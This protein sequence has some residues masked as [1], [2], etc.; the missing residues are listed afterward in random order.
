MDERRH[1]YVELTCQMMAHEHE[2]Q[3]PGDQRRGRLFAWLRRTFSPQ[4][5]AGFWIMDRDGTLTRETGPICCE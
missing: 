1:I 3:R 5:E 2:W 4:P